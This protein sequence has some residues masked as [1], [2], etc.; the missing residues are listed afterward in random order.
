M[1]ETFWL[2]QILWVYKVALKLA[3]LYVQCFLFVLNIVHVSSLI[4]NIHIIIHVFLQIINV[5][6]V[7]FALC[8]LT[9]P[10]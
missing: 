1:N 7:C 10:N 3:W 9:K 2:N 8:Q 6:L 4:S 5:L